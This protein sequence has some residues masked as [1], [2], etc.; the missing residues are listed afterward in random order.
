MRKRKC[1]HC[2][3]CGYPIAKGELYVFKLKG[4]K[5]KAEIFVEKSLYCGGC[6][7]DLAERFGIG[8][9]DNKIK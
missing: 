1:I 3:L 2:E 9:K 7:Y 5:A 6:F 4:Y 8:I